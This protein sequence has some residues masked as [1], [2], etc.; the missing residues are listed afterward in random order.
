MVWRKRRVQ[1]NC[2]Q[3]QNKVNDRSQK[4]NFSI[5]EPRSNKRSK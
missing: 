3:V 4:T 2:K 5:G 1:F